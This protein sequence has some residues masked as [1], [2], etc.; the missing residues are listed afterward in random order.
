M[1]HTCTQAL[2]SNSSGTLNKLR[3]CRVSQAPAPT[4]GHPEKII[5]HS[6][7]NTWLTYAGCFQD[8]RSF[9]GLMLECHS[10][11]AHHDEV[12]CESL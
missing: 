11:P 2:W 12:C 9:K 7:N 8:S 10:Q 5:V 4:S 1:Q 6:N 3:Y